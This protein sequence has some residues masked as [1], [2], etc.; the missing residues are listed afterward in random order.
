V[1]AHYRV[2]A[3]TCQP[4]RPGQAGRAARKL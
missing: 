1:Y 4:R 3:L 2:D